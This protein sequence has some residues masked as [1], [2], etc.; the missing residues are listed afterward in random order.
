MLWEE[1][2]C[3]SLLK[4]HAQLSVQT[5]HVQILQFENAINE[6]SLALKIV[7]CGEEEARLLCN[8]SAA[9]AR[10][11][12]GDVHGSAGI[13]VPTCNA[14]TRMLSYKGF[15]PRAFSRPWS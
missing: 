6:Y 12:P 13:C 8:R 7:Q 3:P 11:V 14:S 5:R 2:C 4:V 10:C 9:F 1:C 15:V